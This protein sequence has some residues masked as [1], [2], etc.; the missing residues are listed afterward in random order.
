MVKGFPCY[1]LLAEPLHCQ[2]QL[3]NAHSDTQ[4]ED[5]VWVYQVFPHHG[6]L[7]GRFVGFVRACERE[8]ATSSKHLFDLL[9]VSLRARFCSSDAHSWTLK[10]F[11]I[12]AFQRRVRVR[13]Q[14]NLLGA[15]Y[16]SEFV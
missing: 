11:L 9:R 4:E 14:Q 15:I 5:D 3:V 7:C 16:L 6:Q 8:N 2:R 10:G 1:S 13:F 12:H